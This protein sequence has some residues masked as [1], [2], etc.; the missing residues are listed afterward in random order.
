MQSI[1]MPREERK[2]KPRKQPI[3]GNTQ[4]HN[5]VAHALKETPKSSARAIEK[6]KRENLTLFN[7]MAVYA[8]VN[9]LP[10]LINQGQV[11]KYFATRP[12]GRII[13]HAVHCHTSY[14]NAQRWKHTWIRMQMPYQASDHALSQ[15]QMCNVHC[16]CGFS[17]WSGRESSSIVGCSL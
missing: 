14:S 4:S 7:W 3:E 1:A 17:K 13:L 5:R 8:Y 16:R 9:T 2:R 10:Q 15:T 12:G 11:V 6:T